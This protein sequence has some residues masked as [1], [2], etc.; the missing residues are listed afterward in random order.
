MGF[1]QEL[2]HKY[3]SQVHII[4][5]P[6]LSG[7][8]ARLC[9][10][11]C[12]QPEINRIVE[13]LYTHL[14]SIIMNNEFKLE[15]FTQP[16][17]MTDVHPDKK[18]QGVRLSA[19]QKAVSVNLARAGTYPSHICYN[20][21][22]FSLKP[23]NVRQD[24]I[25]AAR[26]TNNKDKV[27]GAEFGGMKIGGDVKDAHVIFPDPMGATGNTMITAVDHYKTHI[28]GPAKKFIALNLIVTP[29]YLKNVLT[30]HPDV[31]IYALR[32]DRGLSS[33]AV[34]EAIP[35]EF[36]DQERGLNDK[37]YIVPGGGGFGEIMNNS[38]V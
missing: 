23:Q 32:L 16:T 18:L 3:G 7:L 10:P 19:E 22:H 5:S 2:G 15:N 14:I 35:G 26:V 31:V 6:F 20:A 24:H 37:Q 12:Y 11:D 9:S 1:H 28:E 29:E 4:D 33:A 36:W 13:V 27:T 30:A 38:F 17:R 34:L 21:L 25:F 8:L